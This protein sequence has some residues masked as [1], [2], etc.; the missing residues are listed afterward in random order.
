MKCV[1][2]GKISVSSSPPPHVVSGFP[3]PRILPH[4][5]LLPLQLLHM[6]CSAH[7]LPLCH[8]MPP[9]EH[10]HHFTISLCPSHCTAQL[11]VVAPSLPVTANVGQDVVLRC[12]LSPCKDA[13]SSDIRWSQH[14]TAELVH[15]YQ[16]G[17]DLEQMEEYKGRTEL[18]RN[19]LSDGNLELRITAVSSSDSGLYS[20]AVQDFDGYAEAVVK[21]EVSDP[22]SP[23]THSWAAALAVVVTLLLGSFVIIVFLHRKQVAQSRELSLSAAD[24]MEQTEAR[25]TMKIRG[26]TVYGWV[27]GMQS[28]RHYLQNWWIKLKHWRS[29][30]KYWRNAVK[31]WR[32]KLKNWRYGIKIGVSLL[33][34]IDNV[35]VFLWELW[36][37]MFLSSRIVSAFPWQREGMRS[38]KKK[39]QNRWNKLKTRTNTMKRWWNKLK[40][41]ELI[42]LD[43]NTAITGSQQGNP[44]REQEEAEFAL[45]EQVAE[46]EKKDE[47]LERKN[48][49]MKEQ[50]AE[51]MTKDTK[52]VEQ[53]GKLV[54]QGAQLAWRKFLLPQNTVKVTL[55]PRTANPLLFISEDLR[56]VRWERNW[57]HLPNLQERFDTMCCVLGR[58][59]FREGRHCWEV[60]VIRQQG[61]YSWCALGVARA[62]V[63]RKGEMVLS[64]EEGIWALQ[65]DEGKLKALTA[66]PTP[67]TLSPVPTRVWVFLDCAQGQVTF[68]NALNGVEIFAFPSASFNGEK[69]HAWFWLG[70][71]A[72]LRLRDS[73][74]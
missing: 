39:L 64:P 73:T 40:N 7:H 57:Q 48:A 32:N 1:V 16:K 30:L 33:S 20:C 55:D 8:P 21:L 3:H 9:H 49:M 28:W 63:K 58:E 11:T 29:E 19:G 52:L 25:N 41:W 5:L 72:Q 56:S 60:E 23:I 69:V 4:S 35:G 38:W 53:A 18:L 65:Y 12:H 70:T 62:S 2:L 26:Y 50:A 45:M 27:D 13:R 17:V 67:L 36:D 37:E 44:Q 22:F 74:P 24:L 51:I 43:T 71:S 54:E 31:R 14:R 42:A 68:I 15:H 10:R 47:M 59:E 46:M 61:K 66:P 34:E 6:G